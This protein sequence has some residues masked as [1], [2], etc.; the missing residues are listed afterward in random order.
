MDLTSYA[1]IAVIVT[2]IAT[3]ITLVFLLWQIT[4][5]K[6]ARVHQGALELFTLLDSK[7]AKRLEAESMSLSLIIKQ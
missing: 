5:D 3:V 4:L 2:G 1:N 6:N 7:E